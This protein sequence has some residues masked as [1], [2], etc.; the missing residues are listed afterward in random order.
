VKERVSRLISS[1][2]ELGIDALLVTKPQNVRYVTGFSGSTGACLVRKD[3]SGVFV[4]DPRYDVQ[5]AEEVEGFQVVVTRDPALKEAGKR[6]ADEGIGS[7][8]IEG[9]H[10]T[11]L[12]R[13]ELAEVAPDAR[14]VETDRVIEH[15]RSIKEE[16]E[17]DLIRQAASIAD[18]ALEAVLPVIAEGVA[19]LDIAIELEYQMRKLGGEKVGFDTIVASGPRAAMAHGVAGRRRLQPGDPV[20]MDF[21]CFYGGYTSDMTRTVFVGTPSPEMRRV[22]EVVLRAQTATC[23]TLKAGM[24][25]KEADAVARS[26]IEEAGYGDRFGHGLGHGVGLEVHEYPLVSSRN[27]RPMHASSVVSVEPGIY[28]PGLGGVRIEDLVVIRPGGIENLTSSSKELI[29]L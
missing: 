27:E 9:A 19:E 24:T 7:L 20:V 14:M 29:C 22:Y 23:E 12:A 1:F 3:G 16:S 25:G 26:I 10:M 28:L 6:A 21:G 8:G 2:G 4:T 18:A 13:K 5:A 11:V 17:I 15:V